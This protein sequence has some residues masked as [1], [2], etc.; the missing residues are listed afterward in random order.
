MEFTIRQGASEPILKLRLIQDGKN[1]KTSFNDDLENALITFEMFNV[2]TGEYV[3][4][5][6]ECSLVY[7]TKL[8]N[9]TRDE[10]YITYRFTEEQTSNIGKY[11][12]RVNV[13]FRDTDLEPTTKLIVPIREKL[14]INIF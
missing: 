12:G 10:Y 4:L 13:Q 11:E 6:G 7:R 2:E 1:D 8:Y 9:Q 5:G 3:I 14:F